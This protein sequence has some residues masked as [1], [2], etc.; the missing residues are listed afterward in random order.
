VLRNESQSELRFKPCPLFAQLLA[1][2]GAIEP[3]LLSCAGAHPVPAGGSIRFEMRYR[4]PA[5]AP[6]GVNGLFWELDPLGAQSS[7]PIARVV[8]RR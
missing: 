1:P 2:N 4:V 5:D 7:A 6:L 3:H 8:V